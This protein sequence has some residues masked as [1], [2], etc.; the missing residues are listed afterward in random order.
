MLTLVTWLYVGDLVGWSPGYLGW[1][2]AAIGLHLLV[3]YR[4]RDKK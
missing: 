3:A 2:T 4:G 1:S